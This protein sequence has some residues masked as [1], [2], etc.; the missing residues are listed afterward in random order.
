MRENLDLLNAAVGDLS[1]VSFVGTSFKATAQ[2]YLL[3]TTLAGNDAKLKRLFGE[4]CVQ[5]DQPNGFYHEVT[6]RMREVRPIYNQCFGPVKYEGRSYA[7]AQRI[8]SWGPGFHSVEQLAYEKEC[9]MLW[10]SQ[11]VAP[12]CG[13]ELEVPAAAQFC[14]RVG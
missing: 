14:K 8:P 1:N 7:D 13:F 12:L 6:H 10:A 4:H 11:E 9:R 3:C 5:I 2:A